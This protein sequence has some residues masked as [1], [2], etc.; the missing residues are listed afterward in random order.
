VALTPRPP[1]IGWRPFSQ[2]LA[3]LCVMTG[4]VY[5]INGYL[6][7]TDFMQP[8]TWLGAGWCLIR[9]IQTRDERWWLGFGAV[10]GLCLLSKY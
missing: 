10:V 4:S 8:L 9:L 1:D 6:L 7:M 3:G 5:L 2:W